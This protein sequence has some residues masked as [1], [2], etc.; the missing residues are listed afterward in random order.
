MKI[1]QF[2]YAADNFSYLI[3][4]RRTALAVDG[5]AVAEI[6]A[7]LETNHL[8]LLYLTNTHLHP[9]HTL[10][11]Q[12]LLDASR[13]EWLD[14][15]D[16]PERPAIEIGGQ[17]IQAIRTPGHTDDSITFCAANVLITGD[18]LFNGTIGNCF[19]GDLH[20]FYESIK[21]LM[22]WPAETLIYA[23]HDYVSDSMAFART[24]EPRNTAIDAYWQ[25]YDSTHVYSRLADELQVNPYLRFNT[26]GLQALLVQKGFP[27][28]TEYQR[29]EGVMAL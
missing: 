15:R 6:N 9:D 28:D 27:V 16:L 22:T 14:P 26:E 3:Y 21:K 17:P 23:G 2:R 19:S 7:F 12:A 4:G 13:A 24:L 20:S 8:D 1:K 5:G 25:T 11:N 10:G 18:T 29:W